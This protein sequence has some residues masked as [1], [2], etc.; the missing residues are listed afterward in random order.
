MDIDLSRPDQVGPPLLEHLAGRLGV[1]DLRFAEPLTAIGHGWDTYIYTFRLAGDSLDRMWAEPLV[2]R[3]FPG[4]D[5]GPKAER[6]AAV[7]RFVADRGYPAPR[8]LAVETERGPLGRPFMIMEHAPGVPML[9]RMAGSPLAALRLAAVMADAH[10]ALHRLPVEGFPVPAEGPLVERQLAA[11]RHDISQLG[12]RELE[13]PLRWL[14]EHK[15]VVAPE[16]RSVIHNDFH[17]LNILVG[18]RGQITVIDWPDATVGDRHNDI[19][20]TLVLIRTAPVDSGSLSERLLTRFGR[21]LVVWRYLSRYRSQLP[22]DR[23]RL[24][25]WEA[26]RALNRWGLMAVFQ[27]GGSAAIGLKPDTAQRVPPEQL[28]LV[29]RYFWKRARG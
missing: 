24:R 25:Y 8:P 12:L 27:S 13:E 9:D 14:E 22:I 3:V 18:E 21:G 17:P 19:A 28:A 2:L 1:S 23:E 4:A 5:Q 11:A 29:R 6:E 15:Q 16:E 7:Q 10:V 20:S 26:A